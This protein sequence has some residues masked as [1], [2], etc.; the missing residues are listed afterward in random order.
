MT[1]LQ[2]KT[3]QTGLN[4]LNNRYHE[5]TLGIFLRVCGTVM[6][7]S[8]LTGTAADVAGAVVDCASGE[9]C[10]LGES[11]SRWRVSCLGWLVGRVTWSSRVWVGC[12]AR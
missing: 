2:Q 11:R 7:V 9:S 6:R 4:Y 8:G 12:L 5:P 1:F 10:G 3:R